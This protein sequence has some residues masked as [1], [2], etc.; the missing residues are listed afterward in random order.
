MR[1]FNAPTEESEV[2]DAIDRDILRIV[3]RNARISYKDLGEAV[4]L[5][6]NAVADR[7]RKLL[8]SGTIL[9][10]FAEIAPQELGLSLRAA[11][12]V[13]FEASTT[14]KHFM[15]HAATIP[16]VVRAVVTTGPYD[17]M[18]EVVVQDQADLQRIIEALRHGGLARETHTRVIASE[19]RFP[20]TH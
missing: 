20:L 4:G 2:L 12:D 17:C 15:A 5:S 10:F 1:N 14:G 6:A 19:R 7:L 18:I 9:G 11:I 13:K 8:E 3:E 16:G